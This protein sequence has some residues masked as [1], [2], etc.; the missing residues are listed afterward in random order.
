MKTETN[1]TSKMMS[2]YDSKAEVFFPP[3]ICRTYGEA[4]RAFTDEAN[5][6]DSKVGAHPADYVLFH[7]AD[8]DMRK[9][10]VISLE[11]GIKSLGSGVNFVRPKEDPN[12]QKMQL[13]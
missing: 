2:V 1:Q 9:G 4:E 7:V 3:Y 13:A 12:Q 8:W 6:K 5:H 11:K 10:E